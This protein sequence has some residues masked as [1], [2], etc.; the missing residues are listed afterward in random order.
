MDLVLESLPPYR[1]ATLPSASWITALDL[2]NE[3]LTT[4]IRESRK[5]SAYNE[6]LD[7]SVEARVVVVPFSAMDDEVLTGLRCVL[8]IELQIEWA[9]L[10]H[11]LLIAVLRHS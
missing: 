3:Y 9:V 10:G 1:L 11:Q 6:A 2:N 7:E 4:L 8:A 5:Y